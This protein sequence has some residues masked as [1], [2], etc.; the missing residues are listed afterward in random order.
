MTALVRCP[1][2]GTQ[3][4]AN[5]PEGLCPK[6]VLGGALQRADAPFTS[7][8][9]PL[10]SPA[11]GGFVP[12]TP[13]ELALLFP[14]FEILELL[15]RGGMGAVYKARQPSLDR[16]V[17]IKILPAEIV[18][19][20]S[21]ADRFQREARAM[22]KLSHP[23]IIA[24]HEIGVSGGLTYVVMEYIEGVNL[25]EAIRGK[26]LEP[27]EAL[28]IIPQICEALQYAHDEGV[29]HRD[30]KPENILLDK[31]GRVKIADFGLAKIIAA[32]PHDHTLTG[33]HQVIGTM[34]YMAPE[35]LQGSRHV[36]H[37][38]DIYS[39]GVVFYELLTGEI[40]MGRFPPPSKRAAV[41]V[42]LDDVVLRALERE[43]EERY[44]H[45][46]EVKTDVEAIS[47]SEP[48]R[49]QVAS[50][51]PASSVT[52]NSRIMPRDGID[53]ML[54]LISTPLI[55]GLYILLPGVVSYFAMEAMGEQEH[56]AVQ[57]SVVLALSMFFLAFA[58]FGLGSIHSATLGQRGISFHRYGGRSTL[59]PWSDITSIRE[60]PRSDVLW[61]VAVWPGIPPRG[62]IMGMSAKHYYR[63]DGYHGCWYFCPCDVEQFLDAVERYSEGREA[64]ETPSGT[65]VPPRK[66]LAASP[67][68]QPRS[69]GVGW[70]IG[71]LALVL[72]MPCC[73]VGLLA[74]AIAL[75]LPIVR[76]ERATQV[77]QEAAKE[78]LPYDALIGDYSRVRSAIARGE[79]VNQK[80]KD[81][82][83]PLIYAASRGYT[84]IVRELVDAKAMVDD[85]DPE[86]KTA[87][88]HASMKSQLP[89]VNLLL[90]AG[91]D[92]NARD[93]SDRTA[94]DWAVAT[95]RRAVIEELRKRGAETTGPYLA[96]DV[97][98]YM[99]SGDYSVALVELEA[100]LKL[101]NIV[102]SWMYQIGDWRYDFS[103][104]NVYLHAMAFEC[105]QKLGDEEK[106]KEHIAK[107]AMNKAK[108]EIPLYYGLKLSPQAKATGEMDWDNYTKATF[109][110]TD[111]AL[112]AS[113]ADWKKPLELKYEHAIVATEHAGGITSRGESKKSG[114]VQGIVRPMP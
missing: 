110:L 33:T 96:H 113:T 7:P 41:D 4:P 85:R 78:G 95:D 52:L 58:V 45:A 54:M 108:G 6:C 76:T 92:V 24:V 15:G 109:W 32:D 49:R 103:D 47:H 74:V 5:A 31:R 68:A 36:D 16:L 88:M 37:R 66:P 104:P 28:A 20:P 2:C 64:V 50:D 111:E 56:R 98:R 90:G 99:A 106:A 44:Q 75:M 35:Q 13:Q 30:I 100:A 48:R 46:S 59:V 8:T 21:F 70:V 84:N 51:R 81:G 55:V 23:H 83:T 42:R 63:V 67:L 40:P 89:T 82:N 19:D 22:A 14:Q 114:T 86:G 102:G 26:R 29:V 27:H 11:S 12:P 91:A 17:A 107:V 94:L 112:A 3:L 39:L 9:Q 72:V 60:V 10:P 62:S 79:D 69:S 43:P 38:A 53:W 87:L 73:V 105:S 101:R 65:F 18:G 57:M 77:V 34:R 71:V 61:R 25:R 97:H 80:D 93:Q 1:E